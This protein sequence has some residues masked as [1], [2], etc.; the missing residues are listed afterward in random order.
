MAEY[1]PGHARV[2][3]LFNTDFARKS[4][5]GLVEYILG[6]H[7]DTGTELFAGED[8]VQC[9]RGNYDL[10]IGERTLACLSEVHKHQ[11]FRS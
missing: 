9:W 5:V 1:R 8:K 11:Y 10:C 6:S 4:A 2:L 3:E 7:F